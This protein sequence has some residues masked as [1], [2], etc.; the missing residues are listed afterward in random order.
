MGD[1]ERPETIA[2]SIFDRLREFDSMGVDVIYAEA[3]DEY[4]IGLAIMNRMMKA[5]G[6]NVINV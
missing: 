4:D 2:S 5:A 1:R 3:V 6:Y